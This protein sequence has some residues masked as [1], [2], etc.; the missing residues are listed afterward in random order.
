MTPSPIVKALFTIQKHRTKFL[1]MGGQ[2]CILYGAAEFSRDLDL[3]VLADPKNLDRLQKALDELAAESVYFPGLG[4][5]VLQRGHACHFRAA[6]PEAVGVRIDVMAVL[7]GCEPFP[8][9]WA[10][11]HRLKVPDNGWVNVLSLPDRVQAKKT[12]RNKDW[13]M[14]R[15]LVEADYHQC[16]PRPSRHRILFWLRQGRSAEFLIELCR[17]FSAR[18]RHLVPERPLLTY[19][20]EEESSLLEKALRDEEDK[21][22]AADRA[23]WQPLKEELFHWRQQQRGKK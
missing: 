23:Y 19:A 13:P 20:L 12:Q 9:L 10:R 4:P 17:R 6:I 1:L 16:P 15:R 18:A 8:V 5:E 21:F 22:R 3:V 14:V 2:A 7:H 11:R